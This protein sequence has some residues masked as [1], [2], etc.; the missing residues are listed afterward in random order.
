MFLAAHAHCVNWF[1]TAGIFPLSLLFEWFA[2]RGHPVPGGLSIK[3]LATQAVVFILM[4][5]S[6][7][8]RMTINDVTWVEWYE[9]VG[10]P[11]VDNFLFGVVQALLLAYVTW[12]RAPNAEG[13]AQGH[14]APGETSPLL[15]N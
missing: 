6:W 13:G 9:F 12:W 3:G 14:G 10:Y 15:P 7:T 11:A 8:W 4:G 1:V 2:L 5:I